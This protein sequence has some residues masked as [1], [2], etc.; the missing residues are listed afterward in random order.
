M[1]QGQKS[2][3]KIAALCPVLEPSGKPN[4]HNSIPVAQQ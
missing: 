1:S 4:R 2:V 3:G